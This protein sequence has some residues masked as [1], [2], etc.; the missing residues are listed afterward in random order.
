MTASN[1]DW[2]GQ[3]ALDECSV[4]FRTVWDIYIKWYTVFLTFNI[5]ALG[6]TTEHLKGRSVQ[7]VA[8]VFVAE[9]IISLFTGIQIARFS[10]A[11]KKQ[12]SAIAK[13]IASSDAPPLSMPPD[14]VLDCP[15]PGA[16]GRWSGLANSLS[17]L[18]LIACWIAI[19][20]LLGAP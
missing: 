11:T 10:A 3:K 5:L 19:A 1:R 12:A 16:L 17:H 2:L 13:W 9:N 18:F 8:M 4:Q 15:I 14:D 6:V 7:V 20:T